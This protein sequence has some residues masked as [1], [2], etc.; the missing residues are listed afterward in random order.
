MGTNGATPVAQP[1]AP[2]DPDLPEMVQDI[3]E[4]GKRSWLKNTEVCDMLLN[5]SAFNLRVAR[6]PPCQPPGSALTHCMSPL[7]SVKLSGLQPSSM[8]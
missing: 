1:L 2:S 8:T 6:E 3:L 7:K 5:Y 4:K